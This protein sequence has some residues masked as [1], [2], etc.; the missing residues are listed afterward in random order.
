[1]CIRDRLQIAQ[2]SG[3]SATAFTNVEFIPLGNGWYKCAGV[4]ESPT[5]GSSVIFD[6]QYSGT[7]GMGTEWG[8]G[9]YQI[10]RNVSSLNDLSQEVQ[11]QIANQTR[12]KDYVSLT[13]I[14]NLIGQ[15]EGTLLF[16]AN[17]FSRGNILML[18]DSTVALPPNRISIFQIGSNGRIGPGIAK[19]GI[20]IAGNQS[21]D[22]DNQQNGRRAVIVYT[23]N[24]FRV[25]FNGFLWYQ[26]DYTEESFSSPLN[27]L[28]LGSIS[29]SAANTTKYLAW[30]KT[31]L[32]HEDA[33]KASSFS[34]VDG[35]IDSL[36]YKTF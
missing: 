2:D 35:L 10:Y 34:S 15:D 9:G 13:G 18:S 31:A 33:I 12:N 32:S 7:I 20:T 30:G 1:M 14:E 11:S 23:R 22:Y 25:Y 4:F 5:A 28:Q 24:S 6:F 36:N 27:T 17:S 8:I 16:D 19:N 26:S 29:E 3:V 21:N